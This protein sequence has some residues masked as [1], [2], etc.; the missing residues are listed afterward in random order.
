[1]P[2]TPTPP[3]TRTTPHF[4]YD[5]RS[6]TLGTFEAAGKEPQKDGATLITAVGAHYPQTLNAST[7]AYTTA[8]ANLAA[9]IKAHTAKYVAAGGGRRAVPPDTP[10]SWRAGGTAPFP[11]IRMPSR[12]HPACDQR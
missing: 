1:M 7:G 4:R 12:Q 6:F 2:R 8:A 5:S 11:A 9:A 3:R 10:A